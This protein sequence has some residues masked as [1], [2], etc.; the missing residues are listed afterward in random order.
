MVLTTGK[1]HYVVVG[2]KARD[3]K[4]VELKNSNEKKLL[5]VIINNNLSFDV[6]IKS[7]CR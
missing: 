6:H 4:I 7:K 2:N 3:D 5:E 1:C